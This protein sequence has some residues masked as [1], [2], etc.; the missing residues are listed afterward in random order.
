MNTNE[1]NTNQLAGKELD[2]K[3]LDQVNGGMKIIL[4]KDK[5]KLVKKLLE[6]I[7]K[8]KKKKN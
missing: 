1:K 4:L 6:I 7:F 2:D 3:D 8:I 5:P